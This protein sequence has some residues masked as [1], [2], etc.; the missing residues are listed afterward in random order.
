MVPK[1]IY[2]CWYGVKKL[3]ELKQKCFESWIKY[4][5]N[6]EIM[7][8][9]ESNSDLTSC[10]YVQQAYDQKKYAFVSDYVRIKALYEYGGIY[11]DTDV[12]VLKS[13][14]HL[15]HSKGFFG[16]ENRTTVGTAV[17]ACEKGSEFAKNVRLLS[18]TSFY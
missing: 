12:E 8:W 18:C 6:Y 1:I 5:P 14:N 9:N 10:E 16:F 7:L 15:M 17:M 4:I 3:P 11:L 2:Y 13:F